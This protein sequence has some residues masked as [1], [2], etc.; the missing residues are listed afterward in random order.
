MQLKLWQIA[1]GV[2]LLVAALVAGAGVVWIM[3]PP[4]PEEPVAFWDEPA[5]YHGIE[6]TNIA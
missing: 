3:T 2:V 4:E 1:L 5:E 6:L